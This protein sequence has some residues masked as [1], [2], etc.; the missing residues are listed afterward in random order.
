MKYKK[1]SSIFVII[2]IFAG[3]VFAQ[4]PEKTDVTNFNNDSDVCCVFENWLNHFDITLKSV[5]VNLS[6]SNS[7]QTI[8]E[9]QVKLY[10]K[11]LK[12]KLLDKENFRIEQSV[13][14]YLFYTNSFICHRQSFLKHR[15]LII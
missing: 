1:L 9:Q 14:D 8:T 10:D 15:R 12:Y 11:S 7:T 5:A 2:C 3:F 13:E 6:G 4:K